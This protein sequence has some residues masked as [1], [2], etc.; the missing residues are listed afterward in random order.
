LGRNLDAL[1]PDFV[2]LLRVTS[3]SLRLLW[4]RGWAQALTSVDYVGYFC[5]GEGAGRSC[6]T[7]M[8]GVEADVV[9]GQFNV[10]SI[11]H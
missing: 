6:C 8:D 1:N 10:S 11:Y 2:A 9:V 5:T 3:T 7:C 4:V